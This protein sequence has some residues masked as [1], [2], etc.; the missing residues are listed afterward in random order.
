MNIK[1]LRL[2]HHLSQQDLSKKTGIPRPRIAKWEEGKGKPKAEDQAI[3]DKFFSG[4]GEE[5]PQ[6]TA[7]VDAQFKKQA[8]EKS[9]ENL[10]EASKDNT[11]IIK[12]LTEKQLR[13]TGIIERLV[14]LLEQERKALPIGPRLD[15]PGTP[16]TIT[17]NPRKQKSRSN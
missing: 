3:L 4:L 8:L 13:D 11:A 16:G 14:S 17:H 12:N 7:E 6:Q 2:K 1:D 10:T 15:R 5:V 9:V